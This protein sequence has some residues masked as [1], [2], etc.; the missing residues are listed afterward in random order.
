MILSISS[1][2]AIATVTDGVR[3]RP[4]TIALSSPA[5]RSKTGPH[6]MCTFWRKIRIVGYHGLSSRWVI[7]RQSG[8]VDSGIH[9]GTPSAPARWAT[10]VSEVMNRSRFLSTAAVSMNGPGLLVQLAPQVGDRELAPKRIELLETGVL[11]KAEEPHARHARQRL[12]ELQRDR[13]V[14]VARVFRIA[15]PVD[16]DL[17]SRDARKLALPVL[18]QVGVREDIGNLGRNGLD[19]RRRQSRDV[20]EAQ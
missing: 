3:T 19:R 4:G 9:T 18:D 8:V 5:I 13:A 15:L 7:Q 2:G 20:H 14:P 6:A 17:E 1:P 10:A 16:P 12:E 11:L